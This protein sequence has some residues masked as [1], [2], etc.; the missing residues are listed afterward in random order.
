MDIYSKL[1]GAAGSLSNFSPFPFVL[2]GVK[3]ASMEGFLQSLLVEDAS[4]QEEV[5]QLVGLPAKQ[6]GT[7]RLQVLGSTKRLWW[8]G[9]EYDRY[10]GEYQELLDRAYAALAENTGFRVVLLS[11]GDEPLT[12]SIGRSE[13]CAETI[14]TEE[15]FCSRLMRLRTS[16]QTH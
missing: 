6:W 13:G 2:D 1:P 4:L 5:C 7:Q 9:R 12:H 16:L 3:C 14:L 8:R 10:A 11:T 15:E